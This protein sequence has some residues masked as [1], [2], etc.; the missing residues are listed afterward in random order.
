MCTSLISLRR[1][2]PRNIRFFNFFL[3]ARLG[4]CTRHPSTLV[5]V[6]VLPPPNLFT[7]Q[8]TNQSDQTN[9][10]IKA[11]KHS[12]RDTSKRTRKIQ[13][14][15]NH[16]ARPASHGSKKMQEETWIDRYLDAR[17]WVQV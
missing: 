11:I 7:H 9:H 6:L 8:L 1:H 17:M 12:I 5:L 10:P 2:T 16:S 15:Y 13:R 3:Q 4:Y 14:A